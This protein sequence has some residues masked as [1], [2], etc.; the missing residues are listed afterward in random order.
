MVDASSERN[1]TA[2]RQAKPWRRR[3]I[4]AAASV[5]GSVVVG[6]LLTP[7]LVNALV[8][9]RLVT[10]LADHLHV[11]V[12]IERLSFSWFSGLSV[13]AVRIGNPEG[14][15]AGD[16]LTIKQVQ[17]DIRLLPLLIG[18]I[19]LND[20]LVIDE[21]RV[22]V[23]VEPDG[24][25]NVQRLI[26]GM[27]R[28][29][30]PAAGPKQEVVTPAGVPYLVGR[31]LVGHLGVT[32]VDLQGR[33]LQIPGMHASVAVDTFVRPI[34]ADIATDD[35]AWVVTTAL[36]LAVPG[37]S[38]QPSGTFTYHLDPSFS[39]AL[40]PLLRLM[41]LIRDTDLTVAGDGTMSYVGATAVSGSGGLTIDV[42]H[43][44]LAIPHASGAAPAIYSVSPGTL[45]LTFTGIPAAD[46]QHQVAFA[47]TSPWLTARA[48]LTGVSTAGGQQ[49][50]GDLTT[51]LDVGELSRRFPGIIG[52]PRL[53]AL[54]GVFTASLSGSSTMHAGQAVGEATISLTGSGIGEGQADGTVRPLL[55]A[56]RVSGVIGF[57]GAAGRY[58]ISKGEAHLTGV[59]L[60]VDGQLMMA[61]NTASTGPV[62]SRVSDLSATVSGHADLTAVS[63][64]LRRLVPALPPAWSATGLLTADLAIAGAAGRPEVIALRS[65]VVADHLRLR[66]FAPLA[67]L[68]LAPTVNLSLVGELDTR[69]GTLSLS[70]ALF[71]SPPC[72]VDASGTTVEGLNSAAPS[73]TLALLV[74][75]QPTPLSTLLAPLMPGVTLRG[76]TIT[77][78]LTGHAAANGGRMQSMVMLPR[79]VV[80]RQVPPGSAMP[81][82]VTIEE[83]S[84]ALTVDGKNGWSQALHIDDL[85]ISVQRLRMAGGS[86]D[87]VTWPIPVRLTGDLVVAPSAVMQS[88]FVINQL[89]LQGPGIVIQCSQS[90]LVPADLALALEQ[91][92]QP[93]ATAGTGS[94]V[95]L[96]VQ[97]TVTPAR[98]MAVVPS[99]TGSSAL[100][101]APDAV[102]TVTMA[103]AGTSRAPAMTL[104]ADLPPVGF[105]MTGAAGAAQTVQLKGSHLETRMGISG[106][107]LT[108]ETV[109][110]DTDLV[111]VTGHGAAT[112][113]ASGGLASVQSGFKGH[114]DLDRLVG[115]GHALG[116]VP[117][118]TALSGERLDWQ[119]DASTAGDDLPVAVTLGIPK[120]RYSD[121]TITLPQ[122]DV[123]L[124]LRGVLR[125]HGATLVIDP[126]SALTAT[127]L[128]AR[129]GG[130]IRELGAQ[131][132]ADH[133]VVDLSYLPSGL[134]P[135]LQ[136]AGKGQL[137]GTAAESSRL[138]L[139][140]PL[141]PAP[142][143]DVLRWLA[144]LDSHDSR[145]GFGSWSHAGFTVV[146]PPVPLRLANGT[147]A[148][149]YACTVNGGATELKVTANL[150]GEA[151]DFQVSTTD[152][153]LTNDLAW[154]V[155]YIN[156]LL[157][158]E[159][160]GTMTGDASV[161]LT[162]TWRGS[163]TP[164]DLR[165]ALGTS[166]AATG[167][168][169]A[170][171][172]AVTGSPLLLAIINGVSGG[173]AGDLVD[174]S[175][176]DVTIDHGVLSYHGMLI[177]IGGITLT[178]GGTVN[179][180]SEAVDMTVVA[181]FASSLQGTKA[182]KYLP[183]ALTLPIRGTLAKAVYDFNGAVKTAI[184]EALAKSAKDE[185]AGQIGGLLDGLLKKKKDKD[186]EQ[187]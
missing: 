154:L 153:H 147:A 150:P 132:V 173:A 158:S 124:D 177:R 18:H 74:S 75:G 185:V 162:G 32:V 127:T 93:S 168:F 38:A 159:Q 157:H 30:E 4:I 6:V 126:A 7:W 79:L 37:V 178:C 85:L 3:L 179:L 170:T 25:T 5:A 184:K 73:T 115:L 125:D 84:I 57:D 113:A 172:V 19:V 70:Q 137:I 82:V 112:M 27:E 134:N 119:L 148:L 44:V 138:A 71:A 52:D 46:G 29:P 91:P 106:P 60:T 21:P 161:A 142:Q 16:V 140:G 22:R 135:L 36:Q 9:P 175:P 65:R 101:V 104:T 128:Q 56:P 166:L 183:S 76:G 42:P 109:V 98:L 133:L 146:G 131:P 120:C 77:L 80:T 43:A 12:S 87:H 64:T 90:S 47:M 17:G 51:T 143:S 107:Q 116:L 33:E 63:A 69:A 13:E 105:T 45:K 103:I 50:S 53:G 68:D 171:K 139:S 99:L 100:Q 10:E 130:I 28:T 1:D 121:A 31:V 110:V 118:A 48:M 24:G 160:Q 20:D 163:F 108:V 67:D 144:Q 102:A 86:A 8:R 174:V 97:A 181:P 61:T 23:V 14:S 123:H 40:R 187:K 155:G 145:L 141:R 152:L 149:D 156:P 72:S 95:S 78:R 167:R 186:K 89:N 81:L 151:G 34:K 66:G 26:A 49:G 94:E 176:T 114:A 111:T 129:I 180:V 164:V 92:H 11:A 88:P 136:A 39:V 35:G 182:G 83:G 169:S 55:D 41:P 2:K 122:Q 62:L 165:Q 15:P 58:A 117:A 96:H 59:D 54:V